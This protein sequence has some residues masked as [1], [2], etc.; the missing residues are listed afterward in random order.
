M[1]EFNLAYRGAVAGV[2]RI[3]SN[4]YQVNASMPAGAS[5]DITYSIYSIVNP[6]GGY[7]Y[8]RTVNYAY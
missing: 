2:Q 5:D 1:T 8:A 6:G 7:A 3:S 4:R